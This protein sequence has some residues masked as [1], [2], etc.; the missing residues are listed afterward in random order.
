[1]NEQSAYD[2]IDLSV[3]QKLA[4]TEFDKLSYRLAFGAFLTKQKLYVPDFNYFKTSPLYI[5]IPSFD[6]G[7]NLLENY[8]YNNNRWLEMQLNW[9]S[10]YLLLKRIGF[11]QTAGFDEALQAHTLWTLQ[12]EKTYT[13][14]GYSIGITYF[15]RIGIFGAFNGLDFKNAGIK[16]S[17]SLFPDNRK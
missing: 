4:L 6:D 16:L 2:K 1:V 3:H 15:G 8:T 17:I 10:D 7:F 11:L 12:N 9:T 13:E 14:I 5:S